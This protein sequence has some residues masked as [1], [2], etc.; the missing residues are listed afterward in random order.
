M[1]SAIRAKAMGSIPPTPRPM[2]KHTT[3]LAQ[4]TGMAP[5]TATATK[6]MAASR[7]DARRPILSPNQPHRKDPRTVPLMPQRG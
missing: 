1:V 2:M 7:M 6:M 5:H 4:N 3:R